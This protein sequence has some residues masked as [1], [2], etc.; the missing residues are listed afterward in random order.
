M[1]GMGLGISALL[2][3]AVVAVALWP[4]GEEP[5]REPP[6][7]DVEF[8]VP[9]LAPQSGALLD[10]IVF[11]RETDLGRVTG[12]IEAGSHQLFSQGISSPTVDLP[13]MT[14][15]TRTERTDIA[16]ARSLARLEI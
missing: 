11:L 12:L 5:A 15:T 13:G 10:E 1:R 6:R 8:D 4:A 3:A 9:A 2:L 7:L 16:R 14:S